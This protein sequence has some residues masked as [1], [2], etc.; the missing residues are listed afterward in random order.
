MSIPTEPIGSIP[1]PAALIDAVSTRDHMDPAL[2]ALYDE[3]VR[4]TI[5]RF[6]ATG[7]PVITDGEQRKY[8]N[9]WT[10]SVHGMPNMAPDGFKIPFTAGHVRR[11]PRLLEGPFRY[12]VRASRYL[13]IAQRYARAPLKQAVISPSAL[14]LLYPADGIEGY[15]RDR[16]IEDLLAEHEAEVRECLERGAHKVQID[17]TEGRLAIKVDPT[18]DLLSS[19][20]DLNNLALSRFSAAERARLG[21]HTCPG[22]DLDSTHSADVDYAELLPSLFHLKVHNF[23]IALAG[24][25]DRTRVLKIIREHLMPDHR[26]FIGVVAPI[27]PHVETPEEV[28]DRVLEAAAYIPVH[29]LGTTDDCGFSPFS[30]DT[31]TSR[32]TAFAKIRARVLGTELAAKA[33]GAG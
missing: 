33:L 12:R 9:F 13:E 32:D 16:F 5:E 28:R 31:S 23:Y 20:I 11:M 4:D 26:V 2:D 22:G 3:A 17:F 19:F 25:R 18:G 27:D 24:E 10:Y 6:E 14:S 21:V 7:S 29:Q 1:R 8:H 15:S 30:D